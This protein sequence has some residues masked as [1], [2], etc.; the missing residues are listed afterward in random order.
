MYNI[1]P[2]RILHRQ[3][4]RIKSE[5]RIRYKGLDSKGKNGNISIFVQKKIYYI[6]REVS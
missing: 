6:I 5:E 2:I 1:A 4:A 3:V